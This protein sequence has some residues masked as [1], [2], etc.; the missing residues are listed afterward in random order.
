VNGLLAALPQEFRFA[1]LVDLVPQWAEYGASDA[2]LET[3]KEVT[4]L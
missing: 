3:L 2:M 4:G 1:S